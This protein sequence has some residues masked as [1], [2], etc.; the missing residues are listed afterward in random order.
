MP[1]AHNEPR[2]HHETD[3]KTKE[4]L[5]RPNHHV[6]PDRHSNRDLVS[7]FSVC[8]SVYLSVC[9]SVCLSLSLSLKPRN[10]WWDLITMSSQTDIAMDTWWVFPFF[11]CRYVCLSVSLSVAKTKEPLMRPTHHV[12]PDRHSNRDLVSFYIC[13][14]VSF[15]LSV[16][17]CVCLCLSK[18]KEPLMRPYH[19]VKPDR[20]SNRDLTT[21][22]HYFV[23]LSVCLPL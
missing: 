9:L 8:L 11:V 16:C 18:I 22:F 15:S 14:S 6:K 3:T 17:L 1:K 7:S 23:Y 13:L 21:V 2:L 20:H 4:P 19:H 12:K 5:M 10:L